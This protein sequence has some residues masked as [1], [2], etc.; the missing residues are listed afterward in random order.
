MHTG[1]FLP[2]TFEAQTYDKSFM[3]H[4]TFLAETGKLFAKDN[5]ILVILW[6]VSMFYF[7]YNVFRKKTE[8]KF[9]LL[10]LWI[11]ALP[12][13]SSFVTPNWRHLGRYLIPLIPFFNI[14]SVYVLIKIIDGIKN[15]SKKELKILVNSFLVLLVAVSVFGAYFYSYYLACCVENINDQQ[16][17]MGNW[18]N[19][20][21]PDEKAFAVNDIGAM[22][23]ITKK[24]IV[25]M[26][27]LVTPEVLKIKRQ[28]D[29][30]EN[31]NM[32]KLLKSKKINYLIVYP[33]WYE[34]LFIHYSKYLKPV[35]STKL[36]F[37]IICGRDE[38]FIYKI[39]W[40][41]LK[42]E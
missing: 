20:N 6:F 27:G 35:Y 2:N 41:N 16:V 24:Y 26:E 1:S 30:E 8:N 31:K 25:D 42:I 38:V 21:L 32:L 17:F 7:S 5:I 9:L 23:F 34:Y 11:I 29:A 19:K 13:V 28:D 37:N 12:A 15:K 4:F 3:P 22:T 39:D 40:D 33:D 18:L 10:N 36:F 14:A